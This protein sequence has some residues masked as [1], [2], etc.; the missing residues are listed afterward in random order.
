MQHYPDDTATSPL[1]EIRALLIT[2]EQLVK[3]LAENQREIAA[4]SRRLIQS[5]S[6]LEGQLM[7]ICTRLDRIDKDSELSRGEVA[8]QRART[9]SQTWQIWGALLA[10]VLAVIMPLVIRP[11]AV[12]PPGTSAPK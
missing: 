12:Y 9:H 10:A 2:N 4:E 3:S 5:I 8:A 1:P 6:N 7:V 11:G